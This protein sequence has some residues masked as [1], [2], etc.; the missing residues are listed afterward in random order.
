MMEK[1]KS[2]RDSSQDYEY[3]LGLKYRQHYIDFKNRVKVK[4]GKYEK[5][6]NRIK[7]FKDRV[8]K[9]MAK[10]E[11]AAK[12]AGNRIKRKLLGVTLA[13]IAT[14]NPLMAGKSNFS[15]QGNHKDI[16][17]KQA[18]IEGYY[19]K[20]IEKGKSLYD[21]Q[22]ALIY[23][24]D[25]RKLGYEFNLLKNKETA[26]FVN[27]LMPNGTW[28]QVGVGYD[29]PTN[30]QVTG[31]KGGRIRGF[32]LQ[33][34]FFDKNNA[35]YTGYLKLDHKDFNKGNKVSVE[36][37]PA[38][39]PFSNVDVKVTNRFGKEKIVDDPGYVLENSSL[40]MV[41][42]KSLDVKIRNLTTGAKIELSMPYEGEGIFTKGIKG[43]KFTG[44][45]TESYDRPRYMINLK[46]VEYVN[47]SHE[48]V[49][50]RILINEQSLHFKDGD[51]AF[52][53]YLI[54]YSKR[55]GMDNKMYYLQ[56]YPLNRPVAYYDG[57]EFITGFKPK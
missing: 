36:I 46:P 11:E 10:E 44:L 9:K 12:N 47:M 15:I 17:M 19:K 25:A 49:P 5:E 8:K 38:D 18:D 52:K 54:I 30:N 2:T 3:T 26:T 42:E 21:K 29:W 16:Q 45:M 31:K 27:G 22:I 57:I 51:I 33:L 6:T 43:G 20:N 55:L 40:S 14:A 13:V 48:N 37:T 32:S 23:E 7:Q 34:D 4:L 39:K 53:N 24:K 35:F 41:N 1:H 28:Y 50:A 56:K